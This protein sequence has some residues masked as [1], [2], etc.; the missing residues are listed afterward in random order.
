MSSRNTVQ[1]NR[2]RAYVTANAT[3]YSR[4]LVNG[5]EFSA[6]VYNLFNRRFSDPV[7][8]DYVQDVIRQDGLSF[9]V[10]LTHR[11]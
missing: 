6:S 1:G 9:R 7:S 11:R 10:R 8:S 3:L 5:L 2:E 4:E